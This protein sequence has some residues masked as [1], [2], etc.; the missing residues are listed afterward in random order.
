MNQIQLTPVPHNHPDFISLCNELDYFLDEAIGGKTKREKYKRF[1]HLDTMDYVIIAYVGTQ[2]V[3]CGALR[4]YSDSEIE[5]KRVF[6]KAEY[7]KQ[8]IGSKILENLI[9]YA[10]EN[11]YQR[12][13][14]ETGDFLKDAMRL[15]S[16]YGFEQ[17]ANYG[18]YANMEESLCMARDITENTILYCE[19]RR[20][21]AKELSSLFS[22]VNWLSA[23]YA[24]RL[25]TAFKNAGTVISAWNEDTLIGLVEVLDDG[26]L[27]AYIHYLLVHPDY[28]NT[29][30]GSHLLELV[31][32]KYSN[33][34]YLVVICENYGTI[35]F[36]EKNDFAA[37]T[38]ATPLHIM[39]M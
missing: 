23:N 4:S 27:N 25:S 12:M 5:V 32:K 34:L 16:R 24:D 35:P 29:G 7:R 1:N 30:I 28:Q 19:N 26:E 15:Y 36:Y 6:L 31:R 38:G 8:H 33:Y 21:P 37:M 18:A 14:L 3:G 22:S 17:I 11:R 20:I 10:K 39:T 9:T 2:P 13:I